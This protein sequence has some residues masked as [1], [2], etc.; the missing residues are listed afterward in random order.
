MHISHQSHI[1][2]VEYVLCLLLVCPI[3]LANNFN[4][5]LIKMHALL[6]L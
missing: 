2:Y 5:W 4:L 1:I 3:N 6:K